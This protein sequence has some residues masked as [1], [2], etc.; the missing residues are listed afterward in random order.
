MICPPMDDCSESH[1]CIA[2]LS[3]L[4][5]KHCLA[6]KGTHRLRTGPQMEIGPVIE[7]L[8]KMF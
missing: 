8:I 1:E 4:A 7:I 6:R 5:K 3:G 2:G